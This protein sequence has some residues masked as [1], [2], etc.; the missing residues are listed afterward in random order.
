MRDINN[1]TR[2]DIIEVDWQRPLIKDIYSAEK[3]EEGDE[4]LLANIWPGAAHL[5]SYEVDGELWRG[6]SCQ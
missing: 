3:C 6:A 4:V 5:C 2:M 1:P